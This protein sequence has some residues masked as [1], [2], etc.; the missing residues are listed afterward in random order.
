MLLRL[1]LGPTGDLEKGVPSFLSDAPSENPAAM[2]AGPSRTETPH[3]DAVLAAQLLPQRT[4]H[5]QLYNGAPWTAGTAS[6]QAMQLTQLATEGQPA[7][8][9]GLLNRIKTVTI[10]SSCKPLRW[11]TKWCRDGKQRPQGT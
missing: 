6:L 5:T 1:L 11:A 2:K 9:A 4:T 10:Q 8:L 3:A 7:E